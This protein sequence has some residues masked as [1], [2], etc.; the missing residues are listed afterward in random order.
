MS[1]YS[2]NYRDEAFHWA[3]L[4]KQKIDDFQRDRAEADL[5]LKHE[6]TEA[7]RKGQE[8]LKQMR[9]DVKNVMFQT[10]L[11]LKVTAL[12]LSLRRAL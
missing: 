8:A 7:I 3:K 5:K 11:E 9:F 2:P 12:I 10:K 1:I 4:R 6:R